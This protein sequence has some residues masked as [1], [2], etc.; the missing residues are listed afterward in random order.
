MTGYLHAPGRKQHCWFSSTDQWWSSCPFR[1][2]WCNG[3]SLW[4][5]CYMEH[6]PINLCWGHRPTRSMFGWIFLSWGSSR[7]SSNIGCW[8]SCLFC[9][10]RRWY[11]EAD[12]QIWCMFHVQWVASCRGGRHRLW[13]VVSLDEDIGEI[14][15]EGL[16]VEA[17]FWDS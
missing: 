10:R 17:L 13:I 2:E 5:S 14:I 12:S 15:G 6:I 11:N 4:W 8:S 1:L 16:S 3:F 7:S 9:P